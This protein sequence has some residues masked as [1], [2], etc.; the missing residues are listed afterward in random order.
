MVK[1]GL[2]NV[3]QLVK[4]PN[5]LTGTYLKQ[6]FNCKGATARVLEYCLRILMNLVANLWH[7]FL[8]IVKGRLCLL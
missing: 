6:R 2:P 8:R 7:P 4:I 1:D 5:D 3:A